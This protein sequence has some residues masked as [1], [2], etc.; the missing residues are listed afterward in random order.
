MRPDCRA[1]KPE[2]LLQRRHPVWTHAGRLLGSG[3]IPSCQL[4]EILPLSWQSVFL[5]T[6]FTLCL[7]TWFWD[8]I[9]IFCFDSLSAL[10]GRPEFT[11]EV[12]DDKRKMTLDVKDVSTALFNDRKERLN[13]RDVFGDDLLYKVTYRKAKST[14]KVSVVCKMDYLSSFFLF[15]ALSP[16]QITIINYTMWTK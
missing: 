6:N 11:I 4:W 7:M 14:G 10:I 8:I 5:T 12:S 2:D 1:R 15:W 13:I 9:K 3:W 16:M